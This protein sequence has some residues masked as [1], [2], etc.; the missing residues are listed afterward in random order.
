MIPVHDPNLLALVDGT[1]QELAIASRI[2]VYCHPSITSPSLVVLGRPFLLLGETPGKTELTGQELR[3]VLKHELMHLKRRHV[4]YKRAAFFVR[5]LY[6]YNPFM[7]LFVQYF[8]D[9]CELDCDRMVLMHET[10]R[11]RLTYANLL[12]KL[13]SPSPE[14]PS[15]IPP[16]S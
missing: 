2:P 13:S 7:Y 15:E 16:F 11:Q 14:S 5:I 12:F 9:Y 10:R 4:L 1:R 8:C 3:L 6:W